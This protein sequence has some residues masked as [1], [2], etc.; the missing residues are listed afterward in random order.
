MKAN[1]FEVSH[2]TK[3]DVFLFGVINLQW[4]DFDLNKATKEQKAEFD[5]DWEKTVSETN[6]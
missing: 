5:A 6:I 3:I 1:T 4:F 2:A